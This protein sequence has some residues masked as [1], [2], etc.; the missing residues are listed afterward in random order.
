MGGTSDPAT[1]SPANLLSLCDQ[2]HAWV[3][4]ERL[5]ALR[6]GYLVN[7]GHDPAQVP[8]LVRPAAIGW[9]LLT[10]E[11]NYQPIPGEHPATEEA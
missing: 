6:F 4:S 7:Q 8:V 5:T 2:C 9:V 1:N 11:G 10:H 3:E